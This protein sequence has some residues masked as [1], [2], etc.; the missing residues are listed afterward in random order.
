METFDQYFK[1]GKEQ[2]VFLHPELTL[3]QMDLIKDEED[4]LPFGEAK[5]FPGEVSWIDHKGNKV[6]ENT[7]QGGAS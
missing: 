1:R 2:I 3:S 7:P 5:V 4:V 6:T